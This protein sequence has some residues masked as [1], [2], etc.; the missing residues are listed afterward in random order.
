[1]LALVKHLKRKLEANKAVVTR[2][3]FA[4]TVYAKVELNGAHKAALWECL[5]TI[6]VDDIASFDGLEK[7]MVVAVG[8]DSP[9]KG[10]ADGG[11][12]LAPVV[13]SGG[14]DPSRA[15]VA[16]NAP[17]QCPGKGCGEL[18]R[19]RARRALRRAGTG[20]RRRRWG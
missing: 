17:K 2:Y 15:V 7:L 9:I 16:T 20:G 3:G 12:A 1:M 14:D 13:E 6:I 8:L 10:G 18:R 4:N 11:E 19:P 5:K